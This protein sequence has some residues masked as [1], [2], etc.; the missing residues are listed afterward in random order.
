MLKPSPGGDEGA[1]ITTLVRI[2]TLPGQIPAGRVLD[3][4]ALDLATFDQAVKR[5]YRSAGHGTGSASDSRCSSP[6]R[7][8]SALC[9]SFMLHAA[10]LA[11]Q[12]YAGLPGRTGLAR[13]RVEQRE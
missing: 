1:C 7:P 8:R 9:P 4:L 11:R 6:L 3:A 13:L 5:A 10:R 2:A 12:D